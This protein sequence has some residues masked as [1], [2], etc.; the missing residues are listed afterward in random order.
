MPTASLS[1]SSSSRPWRRIRDAAGRIICDTSP[2]QHRLHHDPARFRAAIGGRGGGKSIWLLHEAVWHYLIRFAGAHALL[3]RKDFRELAKGLI[4]DLHTEIPGKLYDYNKSD[5]IAT[6]KNGSLLFFGHCENLQTQDLNQYLS[7]SFS[8]IGLDEGGEFP[9]SV[10]DFLQGSNRNRVAGPKPTMALATNPY[11]IGYGWIKSLFVDKQPIVEMGKEPN[12]DPK[13]YSFQHSTADSNPFL[14][15]KDPEYQKRLNLLSP[16]LRQRML[17]GDLNSLSGAYFSTFSYKAHVI[18]L[19]TDPR[20]VIWQPW[21][22]CWMGSDWGIA[23]FTVVLWF[24]RALVRQADGTRKLAVVCYRELAFNETDI[25][26]AAK[27]VKESFNGYPAYP[28]GEDELKKIQHTFISHEIFARRSSPR[29]D[30]TVAAE[31]SRAFKA[32][33]L[34]ECTRAAGSASHQERIDGA[35]LIRNSL[36][37]GDLAITSNCTQLIRAIPLLARDEK[38]PEDV[39]KTSGIEDDLFDALKHGTLSVLGPHKRPKEDIVREI[40][41]TIT[42]PLMRWQYLTKNLPNAKPTVRVHREVRMPWEVS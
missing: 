9:F 28:K 22:P 26:P 42:D 18:D 37:T 14:K 12:Y 23:H 29:P 3:L 15:A 16:G 7:S 24:T 11:G 8:F 38:E 20:R 10:W 25:D 21:Q 17:H 41:E 32:L 2:W 34:P 4:Q 31:L 33:G 27:T 1:K 40:G 6:F 39:A 30:Q 19:E 36:F 13:D 5:H 35:T